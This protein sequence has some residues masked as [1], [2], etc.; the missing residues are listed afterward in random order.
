MSAQPGTTRLIEGGFA[1]TLASER[2]ELSVRP[3]AGHVGWE[4]AAG[5]TVVG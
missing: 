5:R 3:V 4:L 2:A 1:M